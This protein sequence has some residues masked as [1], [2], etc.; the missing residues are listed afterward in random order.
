MRLCDKITQPT[1]N[2]LPSGRQ[3][4]V[5]RWKAILSEYNNIR[6]RLLNSHT[7]LEKTALTLYHI[8]ESTLIKWYKNT[9]RVQEVRTLLQGL[10][11]PHV[12]P[13]TTEG[14]PEVHV[15]PTEPP[16]PPSHPHVFPHVEDTSG[17]AKVHGSGIFTPAP[18]SPP[19]AVAGPS[20][21]S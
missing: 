5:S 20:G 3:A 10:K 2:K 9:S 11:L 1:K 12:S 16:Q 6:A 21:L 13:I 15:R 17:Q 14:L 18:L 19:P 7:L 8:N 4:Y